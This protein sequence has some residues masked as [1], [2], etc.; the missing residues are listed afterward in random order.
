MP[1]ADPDIPGLTCGNAIPDGSPHTR[2]TAG[3][4]KVRSAAALHRVLDLLPVFEGDH[5]IR[6]RF[7]LVPGSDFGLDALVA[8]EAVGARTVPWERALAESYDL[9]VAADP[10]GALDQLDGPLALLP[11]GAGFNKT[12]RGE[13]AADSASV[14][15]PEFLLRGGRPLAALH[16]LAHP[17]QAAWPWPSSSTVRSSAASRLPNVVLQGTGW[18]W[19]GHR[20]PCSGSW[21]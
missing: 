2:M 9:I 21:L 1:P 19:T 10:K 8:L 6:R 7:T 12:V 5:R 14:L 16:A 4:R 15:D 11:H 13:G 20:T 3:F 17:E 18:S